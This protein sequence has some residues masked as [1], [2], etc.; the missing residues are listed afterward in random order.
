MKAL[1]GAGIA[2]VVSGCAAGPVVTPF[3]TG[4][5]DSRSPV[6]ADVAQASKAPGPYPRFSAIPPVPKDVRPASAWKSAVIDAWSLKRATE[7]EAASIPFLLANTEAWAK[8][9]HARIP[10]NELKAV[11]PDEASESEAYAAAQRARA[12]PPPTPQ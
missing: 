5:V 9:E 4:P 2:L 12:T 10:Q 3:S 6:A 7:A 8:T 1:I 11:S